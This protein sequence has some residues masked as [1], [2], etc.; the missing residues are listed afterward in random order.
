MGF[1]PRSGSD[2]DVDWPA[3]SRSSDLIHFEKLPAHD[4]YLAVFRETLTG[5]THSSGQIGRFWGVQHLQCAA[6]GLVAHE[7]WP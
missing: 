5:I 3:P 7:R 6:L 1:L 4:A 2:V